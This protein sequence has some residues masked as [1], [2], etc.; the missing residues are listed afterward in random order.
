MQAQGVHSG[1]GETTVPPAD[2]PFHF[3]FTLIPGVPLLHL[4]AEPIP[5]RSELR[6]LT[7]LLPRFSLWPLGAD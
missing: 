5:P 7:Y 3:L 2:V 4:Q 1:L 6:V